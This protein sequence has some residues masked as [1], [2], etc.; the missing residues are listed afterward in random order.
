MF[1]LNGAV[2]NAKP[3]SEDGG[4]CDKIPY[5]RIHGVDEVGVTLTKASGHCYLRSTIRDLSEFKTWLQSNPITVQYRLA[6]ESVKTVDLSDNVVYSYDEVTHYDG[7][8]ESGSLIPTVAVKVPTDVQAVITDQSATIQTLEQEN[9]VLK[10]TQ[11]T[12]LVVQ[13]GMME[14]MA[15]NLSESEEQP[16]YLKALRQLASE[17]GLL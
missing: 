9:Q 2:K 4:V 1:D 15:T 13:L 6:T 16:T 17:R 10:K 14:Q 5:G 3:I 8:S 11:D 12:L 7:S